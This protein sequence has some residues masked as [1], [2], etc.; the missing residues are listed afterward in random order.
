M[1][2]ER[3]KIIDATLDEFSE[4][5]FSAASL[6]SIAERAKL[7]IHIV[8]ALFVDK[9]TLLEEV[10][11]RQT[12]PMVSAI[13][14]AVEDIED[15]RELIREAMRIFDRWMLEHPRM[16]RIWVLCSLANAETL[17]TFLQKTLLPS[18]FFERLQFFIDRG[19]LRCN[20][21]FMLSIILDSLMAFAHMM[22]PPLEQ[23]CAPQK[24]EDVME[25]RFEAVIDLFEQGLYT[26]KH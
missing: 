24:I 11:I 5:G 2:T 3:D 13:S 23:A 21:L 17:S 4:I 15:P 10:V 14:L 8:R 22:R 26:E 18:E 20:D 12:E 9:E 7:D 25:Q 19:Q 1:S 16:I 6:Q